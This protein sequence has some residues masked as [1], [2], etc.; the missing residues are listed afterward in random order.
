MIWGWIASFDSSG[1]RYTPLWVGPIGL[2]GWAN[3]VECALQ[4]VAAAP[5]FLPAMS[6]V[7][8]QRYSADQAGA[9]P[10]FQPKFAAG[11]AAAGPNGRKTRENWL[12]TAKFYGISAISAPLRVAF[13]EKQALIIKSTLCRTDKFFTPVTSHGG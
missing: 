5:P 7:S 9:I 8:L 4:H 12:P 3:N 10:H 2:W 6:S 13:F 11:A 1:H